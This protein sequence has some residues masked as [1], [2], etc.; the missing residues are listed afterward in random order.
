MGNRCVIPT[1]DGGAPDRHAVEK[2]KSNVSVRPM[3][4]AEQAQCTS[5]VAHKASEY[6]QAPRMPVTRKVEL[7]NSGSSAA[8]G[9]KRP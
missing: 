9:G 7:A 1:S 5:N 6:S 4:H 3:A 8:S 2:N